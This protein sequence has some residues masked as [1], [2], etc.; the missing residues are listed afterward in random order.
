MTSGQSFYKVASE[1]F[2]FFPK[3]NKNLEGQADPNQ[4][5][6]LLYWDIYFKM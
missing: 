3:W 1:T 6:Q 5:I 4:V 2:L